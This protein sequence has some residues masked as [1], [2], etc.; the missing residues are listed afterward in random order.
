MNNL[1]K[2]V[3][4]SSMFTIGFVWSAS[5]G[6]SASTNKSAYDA[7][8]TYAGR[9]CSGLDNK[10][11][12]EICAQVKLVMIQAFKESS[13][14]VSIVKEGLIAIGGMV[15]GAVVN[16]ALEGGENQAK[17]YMG[18]FA[19]AALVISHWISK[20]STNKEAEQFEKYFKALIADSSIVTAGQMSAVQDEIE[21]GL[22]VEKRFIALC[23]ER[24]LLE[25]SP[26]FEEYRRSLCIQAR[27]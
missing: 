13:P 23:S 25:T 10:K 11:D 22:A 8:H 27:N 20:I 3:F 1:K 21:Q 14:P 17:I 6:A 26:F 16:R 18:S 24:R 12:I 5:E 9:M 4:I 15:F 19:S 7:I 2:F